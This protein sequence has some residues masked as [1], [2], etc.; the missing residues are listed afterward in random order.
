MGP[1]LVHELKK[2]C[3]LVVNYNI[4]DPFGKRD[5]NNWKLYLK[6]V[7]FYDLVVVMRDCNILEAEKRGAQKVLKVFMSAD[8]IAHAPR[9]LTEDDKLRWS[10]DVV[11]VG[12]WMPER[13]PFLSRL[14]QLGVPLA[15]FGN[16]W[17]KAPE[18]PLLRSA[19]R[20]PALSKDDDYAKVIQCSKV[21]LGLLSKGNRDLST[22]RTFEIPLLGGVFCGERTSEHSTLYRENDEAVYWQTPEECAEVCRRLLDD[23]N[24]RERLGPRARARCIANQTLNEKIME[25]VIGSAFSHEQTAVHLSTAVGVGQS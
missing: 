5:R 9:A 22:T 7:P 1:E 10:T 16:R 19:W 17:Q 13:G 20:G 12:T 3:G 25:R 23:Q 6:T 11:F 14:V 15:I 18:W 24:F 8:E 21:A 2:I 4:D